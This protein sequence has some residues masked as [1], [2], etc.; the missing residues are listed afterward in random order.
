MSLGQVKKPKKLSTL[1]QYLLLQYKDDAYFLS[2]VR[3]ICATIN[4]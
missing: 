3:C 2:G 4:L 1:K